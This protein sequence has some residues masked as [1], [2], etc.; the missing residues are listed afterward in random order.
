MTELQLKKL[1]AERDRL[2]AELKTLTEAISTRQACEEWVSLPSRCCNIGVYDPA[3]LPSA[4]LSARPLFVVL[5]IDTLRR[6]DARS[7][8]CR[9]PQGQSLDCDGQSRRML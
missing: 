6:K 8:H 1:E 2:Q 9:Q 4:L 7:I 5:Q 3:S